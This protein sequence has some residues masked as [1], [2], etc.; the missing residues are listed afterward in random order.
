MDQGIDAL[1]SRDEKALFSIKWEDINNW[2]MNTMNIW[3][4]RV[5]AARQ[6]CQARDRQSMQNER[7][8][9]RQWLTGDI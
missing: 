4:S 1:M 9:M 5:V 7:R 6:L 8:L 3:Y 2:D